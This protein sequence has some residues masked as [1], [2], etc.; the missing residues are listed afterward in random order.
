MNEQLVVGFPKPGRALT[1]AMATVFGVWLLSA[2]LVN[3]GEVGAGALGWLVGSTDVFRGQ[4]W[5]LVTGP[6]VHQ[7]S[8]NGATSHMLSTVMGLYFL[9]AS[10]EAKW[11]GRRF[12]LFVLASA[13]VGS[14]AQL[15]AGL[16]VPA[17]AKPMFF[18]GLGYVDAVAVAWALSFRDQQVR[19]FFVLPVTGRGLLLFIVGLNVLYAVAFEQKHE[20]IATPF[21]GMLAGW[22]GADGSPL[23]RAYLRWR[24]KGLQAQSEHLRGLR[25]AS[26]DER[27]K[28]RVI[29]GGA[30]KTDK[31]TLN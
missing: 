2:L 30:R 27:P 15:V 24:F 23:R 5:R 25:T 31:R 28:L 3:W 12:L 17:F 13:V 18:G 1:A 9:G 6:L 4:V 19:L 7:W 14:L 29:D 22:L 8:G 10:L 11:G 16:L 20:G 26:R 21:G